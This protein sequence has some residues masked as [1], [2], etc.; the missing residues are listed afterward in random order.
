MITLGVILLVLSLLIAGWQALWTIGLV[1][2]VVG[3][4]L[5]IVGYSGHAIGGRTHWY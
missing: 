4:L 1:L 3:I 5:A 2:I